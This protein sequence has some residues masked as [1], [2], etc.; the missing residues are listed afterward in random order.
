MTPASVSGAD[1]PPA[2]AN[3]G[4]RVYFRQLIRNKL[5]VYVLV[6]GM[7]GGFVIGAYERDPLIM[8]AAPAAVVALVLLVAAVLADK[9][10]ARQFF[11]SFAQSAG[12]E[13]IG[14]WEIM[15]FTPLL[16]AGDRQH[17]ENWM[18]GD[19]MKEPR[20]AGGLGH[21]VYEHV[22]EPADSIEPR[23]KKTVERNSYTV[24]V[25][26]MEES[27]HLFKGIF[28]RKRRGLLN[29]QRDWLADTPSRA[30]EVESSAFTQKYELRIAEDQDELLFRQLLSPTLVS[31][32]AGHP[33][34]PGFELR[35]GTLVVF[36]PRLLE[37][38]GT[39]TFLLDAAREIALKVHDEVNETV[40]RKSPTP[41]MA[42]TS[43][44]PP[45]STATKTAGL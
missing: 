29:L 15:P 27:I 14:D 23:R 42:P 28:L 6:L 35:G 11:L 33:L 18:L 12:L 9:R 21:F 44:A 30:V 39:L 1:N 24:C 45:P 41:D 17:C 31:W 36:V 16:G 10:S 3:S 40:P 13:Y 34:S 7:I 20:L 19:V 32:L 22:R 26:E 4:R 25:I 5:T 8:A 38:G 37:D 2:N 43:M